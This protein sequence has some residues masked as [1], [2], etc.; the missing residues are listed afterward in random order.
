MPTGHQRRLY[1]FSVGPWRVIE[2]VWP[3][4]SGRQFPTHRRWLDALPAEGRVW[5][6][7]LYMGLLPLVLAILSFSI[8]RGAP[9]DVR[10][11]SWAALL[12]AAASLGVYGLVWA[13]REVAA[14]FGGT[15]AGSVGDEVGG[16]YWL[17]T[18]LLPGYI[19]FRY[20]AKLLVVTTLAIS[21][22][23]ARGWDSAWEPRAPRLR[24][25]LL[26][27]SIASGAGLLLIATFRA[28]IV[29]RFQEIPPNPLFGPID[30]A[31]AWR[32]VAQ[33][34]GQ[35]A[36]VSFVLVLLAG[37][38]IR[39][40]AG[41]YAVASGL[42]VTVIDLAL[43]QGWLVPYAPASLWR[44]TPIAIESLPPDVA[45]RIYRDHPWQ[46]K[47]WRESSSPDRLAAAMQWDRGTL[48]PKHPLP[49]RVAL[50]EA[51]ST[52]ASN[53]YQT[54]LDVAR[55]GAGQGLQN[56]RPHP[57]V[58]DLLGVRLALL[59]SEGGNA[60]PADLPLAGNDMLKQ[61]RRTALP[62]AWIVHK[63]D[64]MPQLRSTAAS[65]VRRR[66]ED[67]LFPGGMRRDWRESAVVETDE[68]LSI[69]P[70]PGA[71]GAEESCRVV[72]AEPSRVEIE[73]RLSSAGLV[74]LADTHYP[75]WKLTV[76]SGG[77]ARE[78]PILRANRVM[79]AV[80]LPA[81][82]HRLIYKYRP[83]SVLWGAAISAGSI[84]AL[85]IVTAWPRR[86]RQSSPLAGEDGERKRARGGGGT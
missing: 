41:P 44:G 7:S 71:S 23:A 49:Q 17:M 20:P 76:E 80:A 59:S 34:L 79:R 8:R 14:W 28:A 82:S 18:V 39:R 63:I 22:L 67:I 10:W 57:S 81:G 84:A 30:A 83:A 46:P 56:K 74:V 75:G 35:A 60:T 50:A 51:S 64:V 78:L 70:R 13:A 43:A 62:R 40:L 19:Y 85:A 65:Q 29:A 54:L 77:T 21:I 55:T 66:T 37:D 61:L 47:A 32:D 33:G 53:D 11:M 1:D 42:I 48:S 73:A 16:L 24:F 2:L 72:S 52:I 58:L 9:L 12:S 86:P 69:S 15:V 5:T 25:A 26:S 68:P 4:V 27:V 36:L 6:P 31:G 45:P 38:R 3:N